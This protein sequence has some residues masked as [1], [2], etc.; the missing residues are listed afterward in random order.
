MSVRSEIP[1]L[2]KLWTHLISSPVIRKIITMIGNF[3]ETDF[4]DKRFK[5]RRNEAGSFTAPLCN[6]S[7][8]FC[9]IC[10]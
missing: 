8:K 10:P 4:D 7:S 5:V 2:V 1:D 9:P 3:Q 6:Y